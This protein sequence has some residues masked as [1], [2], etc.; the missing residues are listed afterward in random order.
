MKGMYSEK[1]CIIA[2]I[3]Q[4]FLFLYQIYLFNDLCAY[5][6]RCSSHIKL[7]EGFISK[8]SHLRD[9]SATNFGAITCPL[10]GWFMFFPQD[11]AI[12]GE[13]S[14]TSLHTPFSLTITIGLTKK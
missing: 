6:V 2:S 14:L 5:L 1:N 7:K 13:Y 10:T 4:L 11:L 12:V 9:P 8:I 3:K